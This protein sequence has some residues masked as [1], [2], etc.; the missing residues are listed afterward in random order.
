MAG[1][2][3]YDCSNTPCHRCTSAVLRQACLL[4]TRC[5]HQT[6]RSTMDIFWKALTRHFRKLCIWIQCVAALVHLGFLCKKEG[7]RRECT[8]IYQVKIFKWQSY[9]RLILIYIRTQNDRKQ[10]FGSSLRSACNV[11]FLFKNATQMFTYV[12]YYWVPYTILNISYINWNV[13]GV[14]FRF[15]LRESKLILKFQLLHISMEKLILISGCYE[16][17]CENRFSDSR[18]ISSPDVICE[19]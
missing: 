1:Y 4:C 3:I 9:F 14:E 6:H 11:I 5:W 16:N 8:H 2:T 17:H 7:K 19:Q 18:R 13:T 12:A 10:V 15:G